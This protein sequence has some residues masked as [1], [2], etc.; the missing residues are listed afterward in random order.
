MKKNLQ[1]ALIISM[2]IG[3]VALPVL[4]QKG[5]AMNQVW[6]DPPT[7]TPAPTQVP[8]GWAPNNGNVVN[9]AG[10]V[11]NNIVQQV[12]ERPML[13]VADY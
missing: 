5:S 1:I 2:L 6:V 11:P 9:P 12:T 3:L 13:Y 10:N 7:E 8:W 4:N